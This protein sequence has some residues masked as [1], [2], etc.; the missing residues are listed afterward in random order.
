MKTVRTIVCKLD[1]TAEQ[2][3]EIDATLVAFA[4]ACNHIAA[5]SRREDTT[6]KVILQHACYREVREMFGLSANLA[7]RAIARVCAALKV[8]EKA[9]STF[10]PTSIDYDQRIFNFREK[11]WTFSLTLLNSRARLASKL[12]GRQRAMLKGQHPTSATLV[13]RREGGYFLHVQI[14]GESPPTMTA[15]GTLGVDLGVVNLATD[16][17]GENFSGDGVEVVRKRYQHRRK[18][19][20]SCGT[21]S[22]KRRLRKIRSNESRFR[23]DR[24][25]KISRAI[26]NKAKGTGRAIGVEDLGGIS[27]RITVRKGQRN[28]MKGWAFFQLRTF[29]AYKALAEGVPVIPIDPRNTSRTC[30]GCGHCEKSN[31]KSRNDFVCKACHLELPADINASRNI[32]DTA[33][34]LRRKAGTIDSG[35]RTPA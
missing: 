21:K 6:N 1:P 7:I 34:V 9:G 29:I 31:R 2:V 19:L 26:V 17:D 27:A 28:R 3:V 32:R 4:G 16:S 35:L 10:E 12:G 33:E 25:H 5:V 23:K 30:S 24:N 8:P 11:D 20:Q 15:T 18:V 22:A 13:K 14:T